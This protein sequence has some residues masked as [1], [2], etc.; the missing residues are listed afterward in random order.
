[1]LLRIL[2]RSLVYEADIRAA[3]GWCVRRGGESK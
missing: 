3:G 1:M 2:T